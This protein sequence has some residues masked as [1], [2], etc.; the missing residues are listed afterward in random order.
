[1]ELTHIIILLATGIGVGL[2]SGLLGLGGAFIMTPVQ[3]IIFT[4][5]G[6]SPDMAIRLA[7]GTNLLVVLPTAASGAWRHHLKKAV[8]WRAAIIIGS[9]SLV[10]AL[11]GATLATH[12]PGV[13]LKIAYGAIVL[14]SGIRMLTAREPRINREPV[15][16]PWIWIAWAVPI[17]L[18]AAFFGMGGAILMI[19]VMVMALRF[20][21]HNAVAT[22]LAVM[23]FTS[24]GGIIGF[25]VNGLGVPGLPPYS[26]GYVNL[27]SFFVLALTSIGTAQLGAIF[28]HKLH[29]RQLRYIFIIIMFYMGLKMIGVFEWLGLPL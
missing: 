19:P 9:C 20:K 25:I 1:M 3:Y 12:L 23:I 26:I 24:V 5:M 10:F 29:A 6:L 22:S 15:D 4:D 2:A 8:M 13:S 17:G 21:M 14:L 16:N 7:F 28:A 27:L 18:I 11:V